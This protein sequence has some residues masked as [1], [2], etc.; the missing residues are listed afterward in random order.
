MEDQ[1][2]EGQKA[3]SPGGAAGEKISPE[4]EDGEQ[5]PEGEEPETGVTVIL[6]T[7]GRRATIGVKRDGADAFIAA[8]ENQGIDQLIEDVPEALER[9]RSQWAESPLYPKHNKPKPPRAKKDAG[10]APERKK[11]AGK[12]AEGKGAGGEQPGAEPEA[13]QPKL[14]LF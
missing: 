14:K 6:S 13:V 12:K 11:T 2:T 4:P 1:E 3:R 8:F 9:A 5:K 10:N 7:T